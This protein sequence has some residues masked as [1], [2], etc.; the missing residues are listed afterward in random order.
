MTAGG[1]VI[2]AVAACQRLHFCLFPRY[3]DL[4]QDSATILESLSGQTSCS[5]SQHR[6][7]RSHGDASPFSLPP[8]PLFLFNISVCLTQS[9]S[10]PHRSSSRCQSGTF[11]LI[12]R[13]VSL[14]MW[15][16]FFRCR[17]LKSPH[18]MRGAITEPITHPSNLMTPLQPS[19][20]AQRCCNANFWQ[21]H[22]LCKESIE[23]GSMDSQLNGCN[24]SKHGSRCRWIFYSSSWGE[25]MKL[26]L[27][28]NK[29]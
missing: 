25:I 15:G 13:R 20:C 22:K 8:A 17:N 29:E 24:V 1:T 3:W 26:W 27:L 7:S 18:K 11:L 4:G 10:P 5:C 6:R 14:Y 23:R 2:K 19:L 28:I 12:S 16:F 21:L 9:S